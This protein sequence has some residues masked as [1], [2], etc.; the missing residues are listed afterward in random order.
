MCDR[1]ANG[2]G[3]NIAQPETLA[4]EVRGAKHMIQHS[5]I[6]TLKHPAGSEEEAAFMKAV[7]VYTGMVPPGLREL[8]PHPL[9]QN[10]GRHVRIVV[11]DYVKHYPE[12]IELL[13]QKEYNFA[14][15]LILMIVIRTK[16]ILL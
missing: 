8:Y 16:Q 14:S 1:T 3:R 4:R 6:F 12:N 13:F 11:R 15:T 7:M 10:R 9:P 5:V 2:E